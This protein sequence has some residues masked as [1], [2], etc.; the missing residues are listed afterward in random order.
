[1]VVGR[2][3]AELKVSCHQQKSA[4]AVVLSEIPNLNGKIRKTGET[5]GRESRPF[6]KVAVANS[7]FFGL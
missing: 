7:N 4:I 2:P 3:V 1:V 6:F 5:D